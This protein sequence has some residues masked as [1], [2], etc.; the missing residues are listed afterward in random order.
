MSPLSSLATFTPSRVLPE[1]CRTLSSIDGDVDSGYGCLINPGGSGA[2]AALQ[3]FTE[4]Y[5]TVANQ[6]TRSRVYMIDGTAILGVASPDPDV[7]FTASSFA[8]ATT[9]KLVTTACNASF[10]DPGGSDAARDESFDCTPAKAGLKLQGNFSQLTE[11]DEGDAGT[12]SS[13]TPPLTVY[14]SI[15]V[16]MGF[17]YYNT[18]AKNVVSASYDGASANASKIWFG[19][20][21]ELP[22]EM[23]QEP[24]T[25]SDDSDTTN[26]QLDTVYLP[27]D[28]SGG[29]MSCTTNLSSVVCYAPV[30][31]ALLQ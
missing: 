25:D 6:S 28:E 31:S 27:R 20:V 30:Q 9:C 17:Q 2:D 5:L 7:D 22:P 21:F 8:S 10:I 16:P 13:T 23:V 19:M 26:K 24:E 1:R 14:S 3:N 29:I 11:T 12:A 15:T 18:S 4:G